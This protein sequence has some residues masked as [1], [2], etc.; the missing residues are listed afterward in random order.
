MSLTGYRPLQY[1]AAANF[2]L[3]PWGRVSLP[4]ASL[5]TCEKLLDG[6]A[7]TG[8]A[9][10]RVLCVARATALTAEQ[11]SL[12][13]AVSVVHAVNLMHAVILVH[14]APACF[15][16]YA[17]CFMRVCGAVCLHV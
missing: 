3:G 1:K 16:S 8:A 14:A 5:C 2:P 15:F 9:S 10:S 7:A 12:G 13:H 6:L 4:G 11:V 17:A